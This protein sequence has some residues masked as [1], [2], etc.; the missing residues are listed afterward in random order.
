MESKNF[1]SGIVIVAIA[2]ALPTSCLQ[3]LKFQV[4]FVQIGV[5]SK[6]GIDDQFS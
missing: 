4:R 6:L 2:N 3:C 1:K 5:V